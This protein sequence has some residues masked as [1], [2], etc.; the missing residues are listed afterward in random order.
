MHLKS[1]QPRETIIHV[2]KIKLPVGGVE[3]LCLPA[4]TDR[5]ASPDLTRQRINPHTPDA[6]SA[7]MDSPPLSPGL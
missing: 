2:K 3:K 7:P 5:M 6:A 4:A 1:G